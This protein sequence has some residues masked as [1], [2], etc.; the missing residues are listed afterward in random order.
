MVGGEGEHITPV[1]FEEKTYV[2]TYTARSGT[3]TVT[4]IQVPGF[5]SGTG[6]YGLACTVVGDSI[7]PTESSLVA[8]STWQRNTETY[9][10]GSFEKKVADLPGGRTGKPERKNAE[11]DRS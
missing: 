9:S 4:S 11:E 5:N 2:V 10:V 1:R 8:F 6:R 7:P 3:V